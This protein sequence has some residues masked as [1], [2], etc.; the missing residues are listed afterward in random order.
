MSVRLFLLFGCFFFSSFAWAELSP[1]TLEF[2][3]EIGLDPE[4]EQVKAIADDRIQMRNG[5]IASLDELARKKIKYDIIRFIKTR[6]F[7]QSYLRDSN[8]RL[9]PTDDY[10]GAFLTAEE[11]AFVQPAFRK[12]GDELYLQSLKHKKSVP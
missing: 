1:K 9:P 11:K 10:E 5:E 12:A 2:L 6:N 8:T 3:K 4:S 7:V